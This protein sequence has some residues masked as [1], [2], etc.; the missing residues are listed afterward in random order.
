MELT[1]EQQG[2]EAFQEGVENYSNPFKALAEEWDIGWL[3]GWN[4]ENED[5]AVA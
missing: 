2:Y 4:E 3:R 5:D 1:P